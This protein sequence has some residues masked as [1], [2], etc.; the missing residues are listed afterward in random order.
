MVER[1]IASVGHAMATRQKF[2]DRCGYEEVARLRASA[3]PEATP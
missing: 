2:V 1:A 3:K